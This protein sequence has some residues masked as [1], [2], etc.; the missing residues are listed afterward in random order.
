LI[1][2]PSPPTST[3]FFF[4]EAA[5]PMAA[6]AVDQK[7]YTC[8]YNDVGCATM[9]TRDLMAEHIERETGIHLRLAKRALLKEQKENDFQKEAMLYAQTRCRKMELQNVNLR[10]SI[11]A[12][13]SRIESLPLSSEIRQLFLRILEVDPEAIEICEHIYTEKY[14]K[15]FSEVTPQPSS[16]EGR[17]LSELQSQLSKLE[18]E[19]KKARQQLR[20][21]SDQLHK[22]GSEDEKNAE[23]GKQADDD[24]DE[25]STPVYIM[26]IPI[27]LQK[28]EENE[29]MEAFTNKNRS[30]SYNIPVTHKSSTPTGYFTGLFGRMWGSNTQRPATSRMQRS[31]SDGV[32]QTRDH[33][34]MPNT[35]RVVMRVSVCVCV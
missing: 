24:L 17:L 9:L 6:T 4:S 33:E 15:E 13:K 12:L 14:T 28:K 35:H 19:N 29:L 2:R 16:E 22:K 7:L 5:A 20:L 27:C 32:L 25:P 10:R 23:D 21:L 31:A 11:D 18:Q 34:R 30:D 3:S 8:K 1:L 26:G